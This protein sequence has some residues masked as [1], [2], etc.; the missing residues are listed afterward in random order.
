LEIPGYAGSLAFLS[1]WT[2]LEELDLRNSGKLTD[3]DALA[4][5]AALQKIRIRGAVIKKDSWPAA[6]KGSLDAK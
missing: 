4:G 1:A 5:L 2:A 3:L 6:L